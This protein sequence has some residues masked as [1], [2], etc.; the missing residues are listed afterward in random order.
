MA[1]VCPK[2]VFLDQLDHFESGIFADVGEVGLTEVHPG[3]CAWLR[4]VEREYVV[5]N[6]AILRQV[7]HVKRASCVC[8][9]WLN[10]EWIVTRHAQN[11]ING[12]IDTRLFFDQEELEI[13]NARSE[14]NTDCI[15]VLFTLEFG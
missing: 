13:L 5:S 4:E 14:K 10:M 15:G 6:D 2:E 8:C 9:P 11:S 12:L 1:V 7:L 3:E